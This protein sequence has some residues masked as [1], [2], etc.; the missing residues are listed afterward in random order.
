MTEGVVQPAGADLAANRTASATGQVDA[1]GA[2]PSRKARGLASLPLSRRLNGRECCAPPRL[3][4]RAIT[5]LQRTDALTS[6]R[7]CRSLL[8]FLFH[9]QLPQSHGNSR[10][11]RTRRVHPASSWHQSRTGMSL[12]RAPTYL[13]NLAHSDG[14]RTSSWAHSR[15]AR[16]GLCRPI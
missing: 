6:V 11:T 5:Y 4:S 16:S 1:R 3:Y 14:K 8:F 15:R 7:L 9:S 12:P 2:F 10:S 13:P